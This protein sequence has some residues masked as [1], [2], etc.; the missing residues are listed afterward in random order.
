MC[1][2]DID[3]G[4]YDS[5][6]WHGITGPVLSAGLR[7]AYMAMGEWIAALI[8]WTLA[9]CYLQVNVCLEC[10]NGSMK[11]LKRKFIRCSAL[12]TITHLKKYI[13]KKAL[14]SVDKYK[15]VRRASC[16]NNI[17]WFPM[18]IITTTYRHTPNSIIFATSLRSTPKAWSIIPKIIS[19][20]LTGNYVA[21]FVGLWSSGQL[22]KSVFL[23]FSNTE[24]RT[25]KRKCWK[26]SHSFCGSVLTTL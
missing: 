5:S 20:R 7:N 15:E 12:A 21:G 17:Q 3:Y 10:K 2:Q 18:T 8:I 26:Y 9:E 24:L 14:N 13:A 1:N 23:P 22:I 25:I 19:S 16:G 11:G 4:A 6:A